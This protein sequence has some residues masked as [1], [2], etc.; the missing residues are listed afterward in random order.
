MSQ[1]SGMIQYVSIIR[2]DSVCLNHEGWFCMSQSLAM[3]QPVST[4]GDYSAS[5]CTICDDCLWNI[6]YLLRIDETDRPR[7]LHWAELICSMISWTLSSNWQTISL[8]QQAT[9]HKTPLGYYVF[10]SLR[11]ECINGSSGFKFVSQPKC[12][13]SR[14]K[15]DFFVTSSSSRDWRTDFSEVSCFIPAHF[16]TIF[17]LRTTYI[18]V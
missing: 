7:R 2:E 18:L 12:P 5:A 10:C 15:V 9:A 4:I 17:P 8:W 6:G 1:S 13:R 3:T 16:T 11:L 14:F